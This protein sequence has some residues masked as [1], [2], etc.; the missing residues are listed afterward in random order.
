MGQPSPRVHQLDALSVRRTNRLV[1]RPSQAEHPDKS[2]RTGVPGHPAPTP[3]WAAASGV[4]ALSADGNDSG[5]RHSPDQP[6]SHGSSWS[7]GKEVSPLNSM[8]L[9][10]VAALQVVSCP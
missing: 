7:D 5:P 6:H 1:R 9:Q 8:M 3:K 2:A 10:K 4:R